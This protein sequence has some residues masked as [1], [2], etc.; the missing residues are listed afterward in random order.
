MCLAEKQGTAAK[1]ERTTAEDRHIYNNLGLYVR[2]VLGWK[3]IVASW[4]E[5]QFFAA[6]IYREGRLRIYKGR[7]RPIPRTVTLQKNL[8]VSNKPPWPIVVSIRYI[9]TFV[10]YTSPVFF[11]IVDSDG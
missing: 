4:N 11:T 5:L 7:S 8:G 3:E 2:V 6:V 1:N 10:V 9:Y